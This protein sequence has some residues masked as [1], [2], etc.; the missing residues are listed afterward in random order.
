MEV[1][2][3]ARDGSLPDEDV[4]PTN[5]VVDEN[6]F[7]ETKKKAELLLLSYTFYCL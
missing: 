5:P 4:P 1:V 6:P 7:T 3:S 2:Q